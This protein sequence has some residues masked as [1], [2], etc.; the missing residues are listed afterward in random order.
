MGA[1]PSWKESGRARR[2]GCG[3]GVEAVDA[4]LEYRLKLGII[5]VGVSAN[6]VDDPSD[7]HVEC[8]RHAC[9]SESRPNNPKHFVRYRASRQIS[10]R[11]KTPV[12]LRILPFRAVGAIAALHPPN[13]AATT[14]RRN[15]FLVAIGRDRSLVWI[16]MAQIP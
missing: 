11:R 2:S 14:I 15:M 16:G 9:R 1:A 13:R 6:D 12:Q 7:G 3:W 8:L 4:L 10:V 5:V